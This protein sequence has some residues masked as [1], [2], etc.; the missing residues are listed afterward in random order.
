MA[1]GILQSCHMNM[2]AEAAASQKASTSSS[3]KGKPQPSSGSHISKEVSW[4]F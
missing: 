2:Q 1:F 4:I 3:L